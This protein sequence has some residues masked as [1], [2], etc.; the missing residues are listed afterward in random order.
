MEISGYNRIT[1]GQIK[2]VIR[3]QQVTGSSPV[4]G[5]IPQPTL[6]QYVSR[7]EEFTSRGVPRRAVVGKFV[8]LWMMNK[9]L[10]GVASASCASGAR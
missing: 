4:V 6:E 2:S 3:N 8:G 9:S 10:S 7:Y 1:S 5:S